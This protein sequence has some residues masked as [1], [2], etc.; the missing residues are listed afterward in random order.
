MKNFVRMTKL[1][2]IGGRANYITNPKK[3]EE[4]VCASEQIDWKPYQNFERANQK[5]D[6]RNNEGR[7]LIIDIPNTWYTEL[8][9]AELSNRVQTLVEQAV[10]KSTD[11]Q[12]AVHWNHNRTNL[13]VH[14]L[15]SERQKEKN[16]GVWDRTIYQ[17]KDG[18]VARRKADRAQDEDGR[19]II[20]HKKGESKGEFTAKNADYKK[21]EWL[22]DSKATV[23]ITLEGMGVR[24]DRKNLL[25]EY[26]EGKGSDAPAIHAKNDLIR[27]NNYILNLY[28]D[29]PDVPFNDAQ[30]RYYGVRA[31]DKGMVVMPYIDHDNP[32]RSLLTDFITRKQFHE[33]LREIVHEKNRPDF[34]PLIEAKKEV[35]RQEQAIELDRQYRSV[36]AIAAPDQLKATMSKFEAA[37]DDLDQAQREYRALPR[38]FAKKQKTESAR[39]LR[40]KEEQCV[41]Y[42]DQLLSF[43]VSGYQNGIKL[44]A[45]FA[46]LN[47]IKENYE[48]TLQK[49]QATA[50]Y[51]AQ[52]YNRPEIPADPEA[53]EAAR[54]RFDELKAEIPEE[55]Q[56]D[57]ENAILDALGGS[58]EVSATLERE[59]PVKQAKEL[60]AKARLETEQQ[61]QL[62]PD[63]RFERST[64]DFE[65]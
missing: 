44:D 10:G 33:L 57:A 31:L 61:K 46:D 50:E 17:S 6:V 55:Y 25:H 32:D 39:K 24:F 48:Y 2:N 3:Q 20:L 36:P 52:Y 63:H 62:L 43:G 26:H 60:G 1:T 14:A 5:M 21:F 49:L 45:C 12:W 64:D 38:F 19:Y 34:Q 4:I 30:L 11:L 42:F 8:S 28:R 22:R 56:K 58:S 37:R 18:G 59:D 54:I 40:T 9:R 47:Y 35:N 65:R 29:D 23:Q 41:Q 16:P 27:A 53:L 15:F 7:E 51:E 13:H